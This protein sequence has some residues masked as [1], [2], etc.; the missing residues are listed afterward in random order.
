[1]LHNHALPSTSAAALVVIGFV[2]AEEKFFSRLNSY[3]LQC[4]VE[5][6]IPSNLGNMRQS[7]FYA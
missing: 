6:E 7:G 1:M 4:G 3:S 2:K 5:S